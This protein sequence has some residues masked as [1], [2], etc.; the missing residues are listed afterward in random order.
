MVRQVESNWAMQTADVRLFELGTGFGAASGAEAP[1]ETLRAAF[2]V[3]GSRQ[4]AHWSDGGKARPWDRWDARGLFQRLVDLAHP[5]AKIQVQ[6]MEWVAVDA[7][8]S[9]VGRCGALDADAPPWALPLFGGELTL[10]LKAAKELPFRPLPVFPSVVRDLAVVV[11]NEVPGESVTR[12]LAERGGRHGLESASIVDE[13]RGKGLEKDTRSITVR[14]VFR[15]SE[16]TLTDT[17][18]EQATGRLRTSLERELDVT[19]RST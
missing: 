14:L 13:Y 10:S 2:V 8:G 12:L 15:S 1:P 9:E 6:G 18:V 17:E 11:R 4:P 5:G 19:I 7:K 16:R 3:T